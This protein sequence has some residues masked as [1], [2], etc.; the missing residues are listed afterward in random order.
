MKTDGVWQSFFE[1][2]DPVSYLL[3]KKLDRGERR[4][5]KREDGTGEDPRPVD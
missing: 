5:D 4:R 3:A 1:T 2:G